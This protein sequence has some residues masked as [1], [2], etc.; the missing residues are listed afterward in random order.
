MQQKK[1]LEKKG[2]K[3]KQERGE[4]SRKEERLERKT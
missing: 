3:R 4:G 1:R 2:K